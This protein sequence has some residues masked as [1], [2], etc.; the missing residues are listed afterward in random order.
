MRE[1]NKTQI[2]SFVSYESGV[3][4][5]TLLINIAET[6]V[7]QGCNVLVVDLDFE[8]SGIPTFS[9]TP[10]PDPM[11]QPDCLFRLGEKES[12]LEQWQKADEEDPKKGEIELEGLTSIFPEGIPKNE[13]D[14][15]EML[16]NLPLYERRSPERHSLEGRQILLPIGGRFLK[17]D[18]PDCDDNT[19]WI[20]SPLNEENKNLKSFFRKEAKEGNDQTFFQQLIRKIILLCNKKEIGL[21]YTLVD[22]C[23]CTRACSLIASEGADGIV[24]VASGSRANF[25][26]TKKLADDIVKRIKSDDTKRPGF[27][28]IVALVASRLWEGAI[29]PKAT[30][31]EQK[32]QALM[33][34]AKQVNWTESI[35]KWIT[36]KSLVHPAQQKFPKY[37]LLH[38][39]TYSQRCDNLPQELP[40]ENAFLWGALPSDYSTQKYFFNAFVPILFSS[41]L[42]IHEQIFDLR[43]YCRNPE[44]IKDD[45]NYRSILTI[46]GHLREMNDNDLAFN[47]WDLWYRESVKGEE[48][49]A[50]DWGIKTHC[51][52]SEDCPWRVL[53]YYAFWSEL[54]G[55]FKQAIDSLIR[56]EERQKK[57]MKSVNLNW[58]GDW[59]LFLKRAHLYNK[60]P[61][62]NTSVSSEN[63]KILGDFEAA[64]ECLKIER[65]KN[66]T[67]FKPI[68]ADIQEELADYLKETEGPEAAWKHYISAMERHKQPDRLAGKLVDCFAQYRNTADYDTRENAY[69][70]VNRY[71]SSYVGQRNLRPG[72]LIL[73]AKL[74]MIYY[75]ASL[76]SITDKE[77][78]ISF[79]NDTI[80]NLEE[81][82]TLREEGS[83]SAMESRIPGLLGETWL[84][85]ASLQKGEKNALFY[86]FLLDAL[87]NLVEATQLE[88]ENLRYHLLLAIVRCLDAER[89][90][91]K[92]GVQPSC[93]PD[94]SDDTREL[95]IRERDAFY[96]FE[97]GVALYLNP[98]KPDKYFNDDEVKDLNKCLATSIHELA[99]LCIEDLEVSYISEDL[100]SPI[101]N[102]FDEMFKIDENFAANQ[103]RA[104]ELLKKNGIQGD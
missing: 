89:L 96:S 41:N 25:A 70:A 55:N 10:K 104:K 65:Q 84:E 72:L 81:L 18:L 5:T 52:H 1:K 93:D 27:P 22:E 92:Q 60:L 68:Y 91:T 8:G 32:V 90:E 87:E 40:F 63:D 79:L 83:I 99:T 76:H 100:R 20:Y 95:A 94:K 43:Q 37:Q 73:Q 39:E 47:A 46:V 28:P 14:L 82:V 3:G 67:L 62:R 45:F 75:W 50:Q 101:R 7:I 80:E 44:S 58:N 17:A 59:R 12:L 77:R 9:S 34:H 48:S 88:P 21:D 49:R 2:Y 11:F 30:I 4:R 98:E 56:A 85:L 23:P 16:E 24:L 19:P 51:H 13:I 31:E 29:C 64:L 35:E 38:F 97:Q 71:I 53:W 61:G 78:K 26:G 102:W 66:E 6:L 33:T 15:S 103:S 74:K 57:E 69:Q 54:K 42:Y 36:T 86:N